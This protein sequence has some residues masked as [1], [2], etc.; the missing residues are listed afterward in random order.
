M[1][2][3]T[4]LSYELKGW[5]MVTAEIIYHLP[6]YPGIL[7]TFV[8]QALDHPPSLPRLRRFLDYWKFEIEGPIAQV[9]I[10]IAGHLAPRELHH[11]KGVW[12]LR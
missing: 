3:P 8:H 7:Q 5:R 4:S 10:G 2:T 11:I 6:D 9:R 1:Y 12:H